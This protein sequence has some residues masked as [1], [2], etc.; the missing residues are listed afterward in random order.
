MISKQ[1]NDQHVDTNNNNNK[2]IDT[3]PILK[4]DA[5]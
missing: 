4:L 3:F 1:V 2:T 5:K